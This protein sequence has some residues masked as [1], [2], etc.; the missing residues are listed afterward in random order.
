MQTLETLEG[1]PVTSVEIQRPSSFEQQDLIEALRQ[2]KED[3]AQMLLNKISS[4]KARVNVNRSGFKEMVSGVTRSPFSKRI[5][6]VKAPSKY[7]AP[8]VNEYRGDLDPYEYVYHFKQKMQMISISMAK[9][10]SHEVQ[11]LYSRF[12]KPCF[13]MVPSVAN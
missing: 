3:M 12:G 5:A 8:K 9:L 4:L 7:T 1:Q 6:Y 10:E 13:T 11:N 2:E